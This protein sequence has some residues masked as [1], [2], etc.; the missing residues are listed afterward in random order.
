MTLELLPGTLAV[1]RLP[2]D[3][4]L[5]LRVKGSFWSVTRTPDELSVVCEEK[6]VP[7]EAH[8]ERDWRYFR[9]AGTLEF[10]LT[11]VLASL[12]SPLAEAGISIFTISTF[13]T[14]YLLVKAHSLEAALDILESKGHEVRRKAEA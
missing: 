10:H 14:D 7:E 9:V 5:P 1:C 12:A 2:A 8:A 6:E 3:A 11:G 13:D 4:D